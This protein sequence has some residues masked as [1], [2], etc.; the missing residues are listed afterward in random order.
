V[1]NLLLSELQES[2]ARFKAAFQSSAIGMGLLTL[3]GKILQVN[4]A[5]LKM[6]GYSEEE[7]LQ[8]TD[9]ENVY[10][11]D[12]DLGRDM[13]RELLAGKRDWY[14][15]EKRYVRK[16]GDVFWARVT[17]SAVRDA[18]GKILYLVGLLDD[19][20]IQR[21]ALESLQESEAQFRALFEHSAV[22]I[23]LMGLDRVLLDMNPAACRMFGVSRDLVYASR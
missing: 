9:Y 15:V 22:G 18:G 6:S 5:V 1:Q 23:G 2:E 20:D 13:H 14:Q 21:K 4:D 7:L 8:R 10:P 19:I 16:N 3:D 12:R 17:L 11:E